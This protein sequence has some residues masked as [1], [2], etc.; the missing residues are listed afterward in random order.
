[1]PTKPIRGIQLNKSHP[2]ARG[3]VGAWLMNE[4]TGD[5]VFDLSGNG[6]TGALINMDPFTDW[7]G[8]KDGYA[9][10]F[11]GG[12]DYVDSGDLS[13]AESKNFT[14]YLIMKTTQTG[15]NRWLMSEGNTSTTFPV[16]GI[17]NENNKFR[18]YLRDDADDFLKLDSGTKIIND[19]VIHHL[20]VVGDG[21]DLYT[22]VDGLKEQGPIANSLGTISLN[23]FSFCALIRTSVG[24]YCEAE[25]IAGF[26]FDR[27]LSEVDVTNLHLNPYAMF[28]QP[29][30]P[31]MFFVD[32]AI[33]EALQGTVPMVFTGSGFAS[34]TREVAGSA[35]ITFS[36]SDV[37]SIDRRAIGAS[38]MTF[39]LS[40]V[41]SIDRSIAGTSA[42]TMSTAGTL[43]IQGV[44]DFIGSIG[45]TMTGAA[46]ISISKSFAG[47]PGL[48]M[49]TQGDTSIDRSLGGSS[50]LTM[51]TAG[52]ALRDR[53]VQASADMTIASV[54]E[55][56]EIKGL[57][58]SG[59]M[60]MS[61][62]GDILRD[63][64]VQA[65][66][67]MVFSILGEIQET[68]AL[69][70]A[71]NLLMTLQGNTSITR[72]LAAT[73]DLIFTALGDVTVMADGGVIESLQGNVSM[74]LSA[75]GAIELEKRLAASADMV[76]AAVA[77]MGLTIPINGAVQITTTLAGDLTTGAVI[78]IT[79]DRRVFFKATK[80]HQ[81][82]KKTKR[83]SLMVH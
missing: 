43:N 22:Y 46:G 42:L 62:T 12:N 53:G 25:I 18:F 77:D 44:I 82:I 79:V 16:S 69:S 7:I 1:M 40:D 59:D 32:A 41:L 17:G 64:G 55:I 80:I 81:F 5:K 39:S 29:I 9:L 3:L 76:L 6:N 57:G 71:V 8:T 83:A 70:A 28:E 60:A 11:D 35:P 19:G 49:T 56:Q 63:R 66:A 15:T 51:T 23:T 74:L 38:P 68:K 26:L 24:S 67:N 61:A 73:A 36:L 13:I 30:S 78:T 75:T 54:G 47:S 45:M 72:E 37:F 27:G 21:S 34:A 31:A 14:Y 50:G 2:L 20:C 33:I 48:T 4:G 10:D 65:A 52:N 58:A